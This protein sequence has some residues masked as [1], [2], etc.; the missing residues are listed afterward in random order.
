MCMHYYVS[1]DPRND[2]QEDQTT[3]IKPIGGVV[4]GQDYMANPVSVDVHNIHV[5]A[6][7]RKLT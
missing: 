4:W 2:R 5:Y 3:L 1:I 6:P 7:S